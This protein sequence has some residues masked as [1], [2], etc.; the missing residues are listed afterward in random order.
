MSRG[1]R[2]LCIDCTYITARQPLCEK[3][4][5][6][7]CTHWRF[8]SLVDGTPTFTCSTA[9]RPGEECGIIGELFEPKYGQEDPRGPNNRNR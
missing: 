5:S 3:P 9:R 1:P 8:Q 2:P 4:K 6:R 7:M